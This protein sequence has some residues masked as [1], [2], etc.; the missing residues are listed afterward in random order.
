MIKDVSIHGHPQRNDYSVT[1]A[2]I[3]QHHIEHL[4]IHSYVHLETVHKWQTKFKTSSLASLLNTD[5]PIMTVLILSGLIMSASRLNSPRSRVE[6]R[7]QKH[8]TKGWSEE[9]ANHLPVC[10]YTGEFTDYKHFHIIYQIYCSK[11]WNM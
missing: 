9:C 3:S 10:R 2:I 11:A 5:F 7:H 8:H 6:R 1:P 4:V